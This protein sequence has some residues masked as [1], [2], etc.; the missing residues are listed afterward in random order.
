[1]VLAA[2]NFFSSLRACRS[3]LFRRRFL[4]LFHVLIRRRPFYD[5]RISAEVPGDSL[6]DEWKG[7]VFRISGK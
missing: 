4:G 1:V 6:G 5:Q 3:L 7:Y 2:R